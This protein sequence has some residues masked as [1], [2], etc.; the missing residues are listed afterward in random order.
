MNTI[1]DLKTELEIASCMKTIEIEK[2]LCNL[3]I[4]LVEIEIE[5]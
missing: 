4:Q 2:K 1:K 5:K 3:F